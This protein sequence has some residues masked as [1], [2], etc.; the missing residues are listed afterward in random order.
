V[1]APASGGEVRVEDMR[2]NYWVKRFNGARRI[3]AAEHHQ[4]AN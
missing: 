2:Q 4:S 3:A 1:H